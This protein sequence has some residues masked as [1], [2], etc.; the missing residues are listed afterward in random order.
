[1]R[2]PA[3]FL[4]YKHRVVYSLLRAAV[5][6]GFR[7]HL[8]LSQMVDLLEMAFFQEARETQGLELAAIAKLFGR[9][10]RTITTLNQRFRGDF[11]APEH[12]VQLRR[13]LA[14]TLAD[15]PR[16]EA[17]LREVPGRAHGGQCGLED[18]V[19]GRRILRDGDQLG[20]NRRLRLLRRD[21]SRRTY[22]RPQ[23]T[24]GRARR[25]GLAPAHRAGGRKP[26][27]HVRTCW[28]PADAP[29]ALVADACQA[30]ARAIAADASAQEADGGGSRSPPPTGG[31]VMTF[32]SSSPLGCNS[33]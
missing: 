19:R 7:L 28:R 14:A 32:R 3:A 16:T 1:M 8:P 31:P 2:Q 11:F 18:L 21:E 17:Q 24:D 33:D 13:D 30:Q 29:D 20:R 23:L 9:S 6:V 12:Q 5:R 4:E 27:L 22:R 10:L 25:H 15:Q 26:P